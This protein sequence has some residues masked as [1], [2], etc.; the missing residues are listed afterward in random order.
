MADRKISDLTALTAPAAGDF[1]PIVDISEAAAA[2]KNKRITIEELFR[3]IP[4][5]TAAAPSVAIE[6]D[7]NTGIFSPG[8]DQLA[9]STG[10]SGRVFVGSTGTVIRADNAGSGSTPLL[11]QNRSVSANTAVGISFAPNISDTAD[12]SAIIYGVNSS[13]GSGNATDLAFHTNANG[14]TPSERMRITSTGALNFVGA[15]SAGSTQAVSFNGSA[16]VNSLVIDSSGRLGVGTTP[17]SRLHVLDGSGNSLRIGYLAGSL[18]YNLYDAGI[19]QFRNNGGTNTWATIDASG[20]LGI[21]TT[22]F[23]AGDILHVSGAADTRLRVGTT[24][25]SAGH[26][27]AI[28]LDATT[29][30]KFTI[31]TGADTSGGLRVFDNNASAERARID[32]SGRLGIGTTSPGAVLHT[33]GTGYNAIFSTGEVPAGSTAI[34]LGSYADSAGGSSGAT[35][36]CYHN[37]GAT[38]ASSLAFEVNGATEAAR[39]DGSGRLLVGTSTFASG[40]VHRFYDASGDTTLLVTKDNSTSATLVMAIYHT[41]TTGNNVFTNFYTETTATLRGGIDY[42]RSAGQVRYNVTS[43]RR[44]KSEIQSAG[45]ALDALASIQ[46]RSYKWTET[47]YQVNHGFIA[48]ELNEVAPDAVKVGDDGEEVTD[49][50]AVDNGK[51]VPLLTKALQEAITKIETLE[52]RLTAAGIE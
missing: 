2:N 36:R 10:G 34:A 14:T 44:L 11:I 40:N 50:W 30:G 18:N 29:N 38:V 22:S 3:G 24:S 17:D 20:R 47:G 8:A 27:A 26:N 9:I 15:G 16:P 37:H 31:Q 25:T 28:R 48:Q 13:G 21:G 52:A 5:G 46:V 12:R 42:N 41:A 32:S 49:A 45:T 19:H 43:D 7:E 51:L 4:L 23:D 1:L 35:I 39:I 6:G 33:R